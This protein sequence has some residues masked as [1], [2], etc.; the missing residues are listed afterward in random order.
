MLLLGMVRKREK[1]GKEIVQ[2][3]KN[4]CEVNQKSEQRLIVKAKKQN[5]T[6]KEKKEE[7]GKRKNKKTLK[8]CVFLAGQD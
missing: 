7:K 8:I 3:K 6:Q 5:R 2:G 1:K 4:H